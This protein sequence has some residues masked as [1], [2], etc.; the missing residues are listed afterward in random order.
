MVMNSRMES[1]MNSHYQRMMSQDLTAGLAVELSESLVRIVADNGSVMTGAGT[2][3]Y[4]LGKGSL[5]L[6]DPGPVSEKHCQALL[7]AAE[8]RGKIDYIVLTHTHSDHSPGVVDLQKKTGAKLALY[9]EPSGEPFRDIP[10]IADQG[11]RHKDFLQSHSK[12]FEP[13]I[14]A[15]HTPG[16]ASN[17]LCFYLPQEKVLITGDHLMNGST[18]VIA[19]PDGNM[20]QYIESLELLKSLDIDYLAPGHGTVM[21]KPL[22]VVQHTIAHRLGR[23]A[24]VLKALSNIVKGDIE[25]ILLEAYADTPSFLHGLAKMSLRAHLEKLEREGK[26]RSSHKFWEII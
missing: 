5:A 3:S 21:D 7:K 14:Q 15:I 24:K 6:I 2:N 23:E 17:H 13:A 11:L 22:A 12:K 26:V 10:V 9:P 8:T 19:S 16:H 18:V 4:L 1:I 20:T 25:Q